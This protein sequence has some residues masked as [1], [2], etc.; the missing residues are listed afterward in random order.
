MR[1]IVLNSWISYLKETQQY[2]FAIGTNRTSVFAF[3]YSKS[4][5]S[6]ATWLHKNAPSS[7]DLTRT[8]KM[9][10]LTNEYTI[11]IYVY[12][13]MYLYINAPRLT[14][15]TKTLKMQHLTSEDIIFICIHIYIHIHI[16]VHINVMY[17]C[18]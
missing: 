5:S 4:G 13:Y 1:I 8:V 9:Q 18:I 12:I 14:D 3:M 17:M 15:L 16:H 11:F 2:P 6:R 10:H 7:I